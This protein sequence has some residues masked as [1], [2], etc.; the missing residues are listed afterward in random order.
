MTLFSRWCR[1]NAVGVLGMGLQLGLLAAVN[2]IVVGHY[3]AATAMALEITLAHNFLW[4]RRL[5]WQDRGSSPAVPQFL[6]F[7]LS[8][9]MVSLFGNLGL[10][11]LLVGGVQ[12]PVLAANAIAIGIC[13][14]VN[15]FLGHAW[16]FAASG[17]LT[18][19]GIRSRLS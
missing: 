6:R 5:T 18:D 11:R 17:A 2:R 14:L 7:Q 16:V 3:L 12:M 9:G 4:H 8:N 15:F 19:S 13:S 1:F 10:M